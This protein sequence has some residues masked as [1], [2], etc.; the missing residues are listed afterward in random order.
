[1]GGLC[2]CSSFRQA[3]S[4]HERDTSYWLMRS[5]YRPWN[6]LNGDLKRFMLYLCLSSLLESHLNLRI[7]HEYKGASSCWSYY[8]WDENTVGRRRLEDGILLNWKRHVLCC[9]F[10]LIFDRIHLGQSLWTILH[11]CTDMLFLS[12][13][14]QRLNNPLLTSIERC[15]LKEGRKFYQIE[16]RLNAW[17]PFPQNTSKMLSSR[18]YCECHLKKEGIGVHALN[19]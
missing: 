7:K 3:F 5:P 11:R 4:I 12:R 2:N 18:N 9:V 10:D 13:C 17:R 19:D 16:C 1:M 8:L 6:F 15:R 14:E